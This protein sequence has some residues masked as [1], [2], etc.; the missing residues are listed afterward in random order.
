M[1]LSGFLLQQETFQK[2]LNNLW[3]NL[4]FSQSIPLCN[5]KG[6][7]VQLFSKWCVALWGVPIPFQESIKIKFFIILWCYLLFPP[8][9]LY[10]H[11]WCESSGGKTDVF[12]HGKAVAPRCIRSYCR[13][14]SH[15][16]FTVRKEKLKMTKGK[17]ILLKL[18]LG[19][20]IFFLFFVMKWEV[21]PK[22][23]FSLIM[24]DG[25]LKVKHLYNCRSSELNYLCFLWHIISILKND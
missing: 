6:S 14:S 1:C 16:A 2:L 5:V 22:H 8:T 10:L 15:R 11:T 17:I 7:V 21:P 4:T 20:H 23:F 25:Y 19:V 18:V 24:Y 3:H 12:I 9:V 13:Q